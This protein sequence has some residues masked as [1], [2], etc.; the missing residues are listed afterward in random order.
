MTKK[1]TRL[2]TWAA[3]YVTAHLVA[4]PAV[5]SDAFR[6]RYNIAGSLGGEIFAPLDK[7]G[8]AVAAAVTRID[9]DRLSGDHGELRTVA[10]PGGT[11]PLPAP[12]PAA[13]FPSYGGQDAVSNA[14][15]S[16]QNQQNVA[17]GYLSE[18]VIGGGHLTF[19]INLSYA[20]IKQRLAVQAATPALNYPHP[21]LPPAAA[22][23]QVAAGF[24]SRYQAGLAA[25]GAAVSGNDE[26]MGD[27]E[28]LGGWTYSSAQWRIVAGGSIVLPTGHYDSAHAVNVG[29]GN[30]YTLRP[31][32][33]A[34]YL[35][36]PKFAIA[37]KMTVGLNDRNRDNHVRSGN[38]AGG[39][40][41]LAY[42]SP[43]GVVG[44]HAVR[45][46]QYQDDDGGAFGANRYAL[47]GAGLFFTTKL[48]VINTA[49]TI[50]YMTT[51]SSR[52]AKAGTFGQIRLVKFF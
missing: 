6:V 31:A 29:F 4:S 14:S 35:V 16:S 44:A 2:P 41:G 52:N 36:T 20:V 45:V 17:Y 23:A 5:A 27:A 33:Q 18:G 50:Q 3:L 24:D 15:G 28:L 12:A 10:V 21:S 26:G 43:I 37:G 19:G 40:A 38:W 48:P 30:Y 34:T 32:F 7:P 25:Q 47:T 11:V 9:I 13:L 49:L 1:K 8:I 46:R 51:T 22:R 39:E 42:F